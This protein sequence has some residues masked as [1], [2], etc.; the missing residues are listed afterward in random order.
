[1]IFTKAL[2]SSGFLTPKLNVQLD[3]VVA[4]YY[5]G[6]RRDLGVCGIG[7]QPCPFWVQG[8]FAVILAIFIYG[9]VV[10]ARSAEEADNDVFSLGSVI[11]RLD[12]G[13]EDDASRVRN[14]RAG[15]WI[16]LCR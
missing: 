9:A 4:L 10:L 1:M 2:H 16:R 14:R 7:V 3:D 11:R 6:L 15:S 5:V 8:I 13:E 12:R